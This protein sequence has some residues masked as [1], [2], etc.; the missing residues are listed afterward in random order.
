[1]PRI[2]VNGAELHYEEHGTGP[3]TIVFAHGLLFSGRMYDHQVNALKDRY[4]CIT[5]D[6]RGQGQSEVTRD[7]YEIDS[8]YEDA[9]AL[10]ESLGAAPCH[11]VGLSTGGF[12]SMRV[13]ARSPE[14]VKS[15]TLV[16]TSADTEPGG[17]RFQ[18]TMLS[19]VGRWLGLGV[20]IG[21]VMPIM[22]GSTFLNDADREA[23]R[24]EWRGH[25][26]ANDRIGTSRA[27]RGIVSRESVYDELDKITAPSLI[28][29]GDEDV[30]Y[31]PEVAERM[32]ARIPDSRLV[33]VPNAGHTSTVEEP[34]VVTA[35]L[36][37]FLSSLG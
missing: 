16:E 11:L 36:E 14:L 7:G 26:V 18:Y 9:L 17:K 3:E 34:E 33:I 21:R 23:L 19:V 22:F 13:A 8:M 29:V 20:V 31:P 10:I 15:V 28:I 6:M 1:M 37:G 30:V 5:Y 25:I 27:L 2:R 24:A 12:V 4:R 32:H 35:A